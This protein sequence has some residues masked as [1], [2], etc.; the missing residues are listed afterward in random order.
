MWYL[1]QNTVIFIR[2]NAFKD[3]VCIIVA[4][5]SWPRCADAVLLC[6]VKL[7]RRHFVCS[8]VSNNQ[9][10][11]CLLNRLFRL[12]SKKTSKHRVKGLCAGNSPVTCEFP[13]Q[14]ASNAKNVSIWWRH[15]GKIQSK[16][17][18]TQREFYRH[19]GYCWSP[20]TYLEFRWTW[21]F[22]DGFL[23]SYS[24]IIDLAGNN[25]SY[26]G[27]S[28]RKSLPKSTHEYPNSTQ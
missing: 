4:I 9:P 5:W 8:G 11:D 1:N 16:L 12:R 25:V 24:T 6:G 3:A 21:G 14:R 18:S 13:A 2:E 17:P 27:S 7:N 26:A 15:N 23:E 20:K 22:R 10:H 19:T 28:R